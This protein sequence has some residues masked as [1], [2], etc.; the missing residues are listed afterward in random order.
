[1]EVNPSDNQIAVLSK[2]YPWN[3]IGIVVEMSDDDLIAG[4]HPMSERP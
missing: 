1:M 4:L 2:L 3:D